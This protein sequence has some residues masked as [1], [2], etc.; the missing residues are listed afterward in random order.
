[1]TYP[2]RLAGVAAA[3]FGLCVFLITASAQAADL[4]PF[5]V[6]QAA[7]AN[8]FLAIWMAQDAGFYENEGLKVEI[9]P[10]VGGRDSGPE[11]KSGR[12]QL[13]HV[14]M[15]S[16][17]R[18]NLA[19]GDLRNIGSLNNVMRATMFAAPNIRTNAD[20]KGGIIGISSA[21]SESDSATTLVLRRIGLSRE[22]V[23]VKEVGTDRLSPLRSGA[24]AATLMSELQ[25]AQALALGL[26]VVVDLYAERIAWLYSGLTVDRGYVQSNRDALKHFLRATIDGN[27][28]ALTDPARAK[29]VLAKELKLTDAKLIGESYENFRIESPPNAEIDRTGAQNVLSAVA[30]PSAS[31]NL[32]DYI[33]TTLI[34]DLRRE[35]F[36]EAM[37][38]KYGRK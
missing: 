17:I 27:R 8:T 2:D 22:D 33:D 5:R 16:V 36:I 26:R 15:S 29:T 35:G 12:L 21:G 9:V 7:P 10:M 6:G 34:E 4:I 13:Y 24:I 3:A 14:G 25:R 38:K 1:M 11:L 32:D 31:R 20:L 28:L 23:I 30:P 19:G 18:A 37:E